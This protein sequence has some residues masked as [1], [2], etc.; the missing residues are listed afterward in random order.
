M[1]VGE[2]MDYNGRER[3]REREREKEKE[4]ENTSKWKRST[5]ATDSSLNGNPTNNWQ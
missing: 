1:G 5:E 4:I 2:L 3:E